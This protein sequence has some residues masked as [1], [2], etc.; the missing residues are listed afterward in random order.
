[1]V[2]RQAFPAPQRGGALR[3]PLPVGRGPLAADFFDA[4]EYVRLAAKHGLRISQLALD[5]TRGKRTYDVTARRSG[6][7]VHRSTVG[8]PGNCSDVH[9]P[10]AAASWR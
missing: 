3:V 1:M 7:E 5:A 4:D 9:R 10:P 8:G 6:G 2:V